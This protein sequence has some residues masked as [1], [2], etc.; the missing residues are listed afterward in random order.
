V[1]YRAGGADVIEIDPPRQGLRRH[2]LFVLGSFVPKRCERCAAGRPAIM[3]ACQMPQQEG[4]MTGLLP[5]IWSIP[6]CFA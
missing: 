5:M 3:A 2:A 1:L 4:L 6:F